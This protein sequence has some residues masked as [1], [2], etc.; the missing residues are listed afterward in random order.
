MKTKYIMLRVVVTIISGLCIFIPVQSQELTFTRQDTL[1]GSIT[2]ERR[3]WDLKYYHLD[4]AVHPGDSTIEGKNTILYSVL[5]PYQIMQIDLQPP[6]TIYKAVQGG[7]SLEIIHEGNAHFILL[8]ALQHP[9]TTNEL[10]VFYG[11][12]PQVAE[13]PPWFGGIYWNIDNNGF[14]FIAS[15]CQKIG[16]S[17]WWPCKD[18]MYDE[19]DSMLISVNVPKNLTAVSNGRFKKVDEKENGSHTFHWFVSNPISNYVVNINIADYAHF[20]DKYL[21]EKGILDLDYYVLKDSLEIAKVHFKEV[22]RMLEAFEY[23]FGP[24]PFY[25]DGYK[26]V[27]VPYAGMEHQSSITYG[28]CFCNG[29]YGINS[30]GTVWA[31]KFDYIII[32]ESAHEWFAN[33]I[34]YKD[35]ADMWIHEGFANYSEYLYVEYYYGQQAGSEYARGERQVIMNDKPIIGFYDVNNEGSFDMYRKGGN[36]LHTLRQIVND[37]K[38]WREILRGINREFYNQVV[39]TEQIENYLVENAGI[40][41]SFFDQYLRDVRIPVFEYYI[42]EGSFFYRWTNCLPWFKMPVKVYLSQEE[43]WLYP[44][45]DWK[46]TEVKDEKIVVEV[47]PDFYVTSM[48][49]TN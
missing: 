19:P 44:T 39:T 27:H 11:G 49:F 7:E 45:V 10:E 3:W 40:D 17:I 41:P 14:P 6:L 37:D 15:S 46:N 30:S 13:N 24:Y 12:K 32:H 48:K 33:S 16:A 43:T 26:L 36:M 28:N 9:G 2:H 31:E 29:F 38:K 8:F 23:W 35:I 42:K 25:E 18:H 1:R 47:D 34:T 21:G 4:I 5:E 22:N 20:S